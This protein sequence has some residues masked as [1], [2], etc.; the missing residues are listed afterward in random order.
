MTSVAQQRKIIEDVLAF[1]N[2]NML[3]HLRQQLDLARAQPT[4]TMIPKEKQ[5]TL[6]AARDA[7][8]KEQARRKHT[9]EAMS[10]L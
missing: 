7:I 8:V 4:F 9:N 5:R 3:A 10:Q 6:D 1:L 2:E